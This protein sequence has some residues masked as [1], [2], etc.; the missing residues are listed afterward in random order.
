MQE[1]PLS[2]DVKKLE[3]S[4][5]NIWVGTFDE[6]RLIATA[7]Q[8]PQLMLDSLQSEESDGPLAQEIAE[9]R[10]MSPSRSKGKD[11]ARIKQSNLGPLLKRYRT[12]MDM[13]TTT[14]QKAIDELKRSKTARAA[15]SQ[16]GNAVYE[17][18]RTRITSSRDYAVVRLTLSAGHVESDIHRHCGDELIYVSRGQIAVDLKDNGL[19]VHLNEGDL[20]A[21]HSEQLHCLK[22]IGAEAKVIVVR[23]LQFDRLGSRYSF[24]NS[25][26]AEMPM[27]RTA[28]Q[29]AI[30]E[31]VVKLYGRIRAE[32]QRTLLPYEHRSHNGPRKVLDREVVDRHELGRFLQ[33]SATK[34]PRLDAL[35]ASKAKSKKKHMLYQG[36]LPVDGKTLLGLAE[37]FGLERFLLYDFLLPAYRPAVVIRA[38]SGT[39]PD[40]DWERLPDEFQTN[41]GVVYHVPKR[42]LADAELSIAR[43]DLESQGK[44]RINSHPGFELI[45]PLSGTVSIHVQNGTTDVITGTHQYAEFDSKVFHHV[46]NHTDELASCLVFRVCPTSVA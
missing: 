42:R 33:R 19:T 15:P 5:R 36:E 32:L 18:P 11:Q 45:I 30:V 2:T 13:T 41:K 44:T 9:E 38:S 16:H 25:L 1:I 23:F 29:M 40:S 43:V 21:F 39:D 12:T 37:A 6:F 20:I 28:K 4:S 14:V 22:C 3:Q 24:L 26:P 27:P 17:V 35:F 10:W 34:A 46:E 7:Y 8:L 31:K